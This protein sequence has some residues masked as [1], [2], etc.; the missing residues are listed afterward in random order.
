MQW[1]HTVYTNTEPHLTDV[2]KTETKNN[3]K[4]QDYKNTQKKNIKT[5]NKSI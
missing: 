4:K 1:N 5:L 2:D 3:V